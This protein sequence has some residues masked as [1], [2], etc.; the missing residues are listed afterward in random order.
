MCNVQCVQCAVQCGVVS[1]WEGGDCWRGCRERLKRRKRLKRSLSSSCSSIN[2][3][4]RNIYV[5]N[6]SEEKW[7]RGF[8]AIVWLKPLHSVSHLDDQCCLVWNVTDLEPETN[9]SKSGFCNEAS[10]QPTAIVPWRKLSESS[11]I[12]VVIV[13]LE[14]LSKDQ[15]QS[16]LCFSINDQS[17]SNHRWCCSAAY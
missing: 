12:K 16:D 8:S 14:H 2:H 7:K 13:K 9:V 1:A 15:S 10:H 17:V 4:W 11:V 6:D 3:P 5:D